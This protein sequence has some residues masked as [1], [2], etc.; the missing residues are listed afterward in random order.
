VWDIT[1]RVLLIAVIGSITP[2]HLRQ[3]ANNVH[4]R[5][6]QSRRKQQPYV[7]NPMRG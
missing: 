7:R 3:A 5:L 2:D 6:A 4:R 1:R